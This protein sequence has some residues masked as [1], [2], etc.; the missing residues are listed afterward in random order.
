[1]PLTIRPATLSDV[2]AILAIERQADTAAHWTSAQYET[3]L[4]SGV[5]LVADAAATLRGFICAKAVAGEWEIENVVVAPEFLRRGI[6]SKL[7]CALI[8]RAKEEA[9]SAILLEVRESNLPARRLYEKYGFRAVGHRR[10]H[11]R[12]PAEDAILYALRFD[13]LRFD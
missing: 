6:A 11:Y 5:V 4:E 1:M 12:D 3:L 2:P 8:Q 7:V 13:S 10:A 9:G